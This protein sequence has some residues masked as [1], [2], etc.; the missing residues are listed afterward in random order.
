MHRLGIG[1]FC[2]DKIGDLKMTK[3][4]LTKKFEKLESKFNELEKRLTELEKKSQV[5][6]HYHY[7]SYPIYWPTPTLTVSSGP[8]ETRS[9]A[10][11]G[12]WTFS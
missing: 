1:L 5:V 6:N 11:I 9:D 7:Y 12:N 2:W 3:R 10:N 4:E 8:A